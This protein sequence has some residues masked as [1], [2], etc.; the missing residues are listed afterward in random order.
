MDRE[1]W[2][3]AVHGVAKSRTRLSDWTELTRDG[4]DIIQSAS[5]VTSKL[6]L[7]GGQLAAE[8]QGEVHTGLTDTV[9]LVR[10]AGVLW[11]S[12]VCLWVRPREPL[13]T[14]LHG[15]HWTAAGSDAPPGVY[16][17]VLEG[18]HWQL[19]REPST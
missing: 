8:Q 1:A 11:H 6:S 19:Q 12:A 13:L 10:E 15:T 7:L 17:S 3:A 18:E 4:D 16:S 9:T 2:W 14:G 5:S